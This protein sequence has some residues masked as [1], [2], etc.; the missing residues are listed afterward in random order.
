MATITREQAIEY[1]NSLG[2]PVDWD[3]SE[4]NHTSEDAW[5]LE[6]I[7][8]EVKR[9]DAYDGGGIW[10]SILQ[11]YNAQDVKGL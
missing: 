6:Q 7:R 5:T 8:D 1:L 4:N 3:N 2:D 9:G 11:T 10:E